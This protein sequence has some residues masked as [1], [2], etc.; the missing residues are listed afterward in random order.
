MGLNLRCESMPFA[1]IIRVKFLYHLFISFPPLYL[2]I[3]VH[4]HIRF[5]IVAF[6]WCRSGTRENNAG[7]DWPMIFCYIREYS[8]W[9]RRPKCCLEICVR[10]ERVQLPFLVR[11]GARDARQLPIYFC[12]LPHQHPWLVR[13]DRYVLVQWPHK[14][15]YVANACNVN[16]PGHVIFTWHHDCRSEDKFVSCPFPFSKTLPHSKS[17]TIIGSLF[18]F[19]EKTINDWLKRKLWKCLPCS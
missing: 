2:N 4:R 12:P 10:N 5:Y 14:L 17:R 8:S 9:K 19:L 7:S 1:N 16:S 6:L 13:W 15:D 3:D 11:S 18:S